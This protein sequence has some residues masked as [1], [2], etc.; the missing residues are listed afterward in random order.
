MGLIVKLEYVLHECSDSDDHSLELLLVE[1]DI[2]IAIYMHLYWKTYT[3][4]IM[5]KSMIS[6][7]KYRGESG[8]ATRDQY[9]SH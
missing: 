2:L 1:R 5:C 3:L 7:W 4:Y 9:P 6:K 8:L